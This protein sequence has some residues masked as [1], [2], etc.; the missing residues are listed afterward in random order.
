MN[1][2]TIV[3]PGK[4]GHWRRSRTNG[5]RHFLHPSSK[6]E[7]ERIQ[8]H[9]KRAWPHGPLDKSVTVTIDAFFPRTK[10]R[11]KGVAKEVWQSGVAL[12][13]VT[14]GDVDNIGKQV[15]DACNEILWKDDA[16]VTD[17]R[18]R[19]FWSADGS[20]PCTLVMMRWSE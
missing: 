11:P 10:T 20:D 19:K 15:L 18:V 5:K 2:V 9:A 16:L 4:P 1:L 8:L 3:I 12:P 6:E 14:R 7:R 13:K 17:L